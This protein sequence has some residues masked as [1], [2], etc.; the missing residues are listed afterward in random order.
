MRITIDAR[1]Y[2]QTGVGRY[3]RNILKYV[4][5]YDT[6]NSYC[7]IL[8]S[9]AY[10]DFRVPGSK[11]T[12][13]RCDVHWHTVREQ[14]VMPVIYAQT[15]PDLVHIPYFSVPVLY[16]GRTILTIHD[17]TVLAQTTG[18]ASTLPFPL[19]SIKKIALM[20][21]LRSGIDH[22]ARIIAVSKTVGK[23][24]SGRYEGVSEKITVI[25]EGIDEIFLEPSKNK[26]VHHSYFLYVGNAYPHKNLDTLMRAYGIFSTSIQKP[27]RL[28]LVGKKDIFYQRLMKETQDRNIQFYGHA[29][30]ETLA[31]LYR[32]ALALIFPSKAEGF[33]LPVLEAYAQSCPL[34]LSDLPV[35]H[36]TVGDHASY[37]DADDIETL[38]GLMKKAVRA[39]AAGGKPDAA[40]LDKFSWK[41]CARNT[42]ETYENCARV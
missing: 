26:P 35:F 29:N 24:I 34:I 10:G 40:L 9:D 38:T 4:S 17:L 13:I 1:L 16:R 36:D 6:V 21:V 28:I 2:Y 25:P 30:D 32:H 22:A 11:W 18:K 20:H 41:K 7:I 23:D 12:K 37:F 39:R 33:G 8:G 31:G 3:I 5:K 42:L 14:I 27:P 15:Q 19:Y